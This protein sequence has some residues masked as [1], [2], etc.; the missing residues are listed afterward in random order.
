MVVLARDSVESLR[1]S[2]ETRV[3]ASLAGTELARVFPSKT[4]V[5][6][7]AVVALADCGNAIRPAR[8]RRPARTN[9][10]V[11]LDSDMILDVRTVAMGFPSMI[12]F[13]L[14]TLTLGLRQ[15]RAGYQQAVKNR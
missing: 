4:I 2:D 7:A 1:E 3:E 11:F 12:N 9:A 5:G 10:V 15:S 6:F 13:L 8:A 14:L